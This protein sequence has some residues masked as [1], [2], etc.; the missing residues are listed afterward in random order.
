[1][2]VKKKDSRPK[3]VANIYKTLESLIMMTDDV[4]DL[5]MLSVV[6]FISAK[7]VMLAAHGNTKTRAILEQLLEELNAAKALPKPE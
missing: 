6:M 3:K 7:Q 2:P 1:M 4:D 5:T